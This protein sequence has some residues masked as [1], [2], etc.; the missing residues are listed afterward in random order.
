MF[1]LAKTNYG[2]A[3]L[4]MFSICEINR[5]SV[6]AAPTL[7]LTI[8]GNNMHTGEICAHACVL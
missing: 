8:W 5:S 3:C 4:G 7:R 1:H 2:N 6:L